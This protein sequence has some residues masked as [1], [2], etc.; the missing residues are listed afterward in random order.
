MEQS[1]DMKTKKKEFEIIPIFNKN[2]EKI[3]T[4][5]QNAF[6]KFLNYNDYK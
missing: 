3:E 5:I 2:G 1:N 6:L 4:V